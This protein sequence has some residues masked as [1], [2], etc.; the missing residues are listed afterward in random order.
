MPITRVTAEWRGFPGAPGYSTFHFHDSPSGPVVD[1]ARQRVHDF[2]NELRGTLPTSVEISVREEVEEYDESTGL[3]VGYERGTE[4]LPTVSGSNI[5]D[6]AGPVG[7]VIHWNTNTVANGRRLRGRTFIVPMMRTAYESDGTIDDTQ[8]E[9]LNDG[10][11]HLS[12]GG[13]ESTF[14]VWSRPQSGGSGAVGPVVSHRV[15][16]MAAVLRSRRD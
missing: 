5:A 2:F 12:G 6:Y 13:F 15:P 7:A 14:C 8:L 1:E 4:T 10:A 3:L 16:D 11:A 9:R